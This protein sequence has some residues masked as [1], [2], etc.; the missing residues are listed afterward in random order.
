MYGRLLSEVL[1]EVIETG[2]QYDS[3]SER[4]S[5]LVRKGRSRTPDETKLMKLL[6]VLVRDYDQRN[7]LPPASIPAHEA[8]RFLLDHSGKTP[9][10]LLSV[11]GQRSHVNEALNGKRPI[12]AGQARKLARMFSVNPGVFIKAGV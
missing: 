7:A 8:V 10:D 3:I 9:A 6:A 11:F 5:E 2:E 12:S 4:L 1:P